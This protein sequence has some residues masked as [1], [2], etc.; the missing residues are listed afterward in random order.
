MI[1]VLEIA[2]TAPANRLSRTV[3]PNSRPMTKSQHVRA[4]DQAGDDVAEDYGLAQALADDGRDR[5]H[6]QHDRQGAK[7]LVGRPAWSAQ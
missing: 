3:H 5:R 2:M 1:V 4:D 6:A 7:E